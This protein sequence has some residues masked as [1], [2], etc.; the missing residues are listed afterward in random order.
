M[1][2]TEYELPANTQK[3]PEINT[4]KTR[5]HELLNNLRYYLSL[6]PHD[7]K[8]FENS[9]Q[10][11]IENFE[12]LAHALKSD[13]EDPESPLTFDR[14]INIIIAL[15]NKDG[16]DD[17]E[18]AKLAQK[19][20]DDFIQEYL[21]KIRSNQFLLDDSTIFTERLCF[22]LALS[23]CGSAGNEED[24]KASFY[25][26]K[27]IILKWGLNHVDLIN[28]WGDSFPKAKTLPIQEDGVQYIYKN[29]S[30]A[31]ILE[32]KRPGIVKVLVTEFGVKAFARYPLDSLIKQY[33]ERDKDDKPYGIILYARKDWNGAFTL[34][35][36]LFQK[37]SSDLDRCGYYLRIIEADSKI[38][39]A[40][41]LITFRKRYPN[42]K[43][44]FAL[45]GGHGTRSSIN[46]GGNDELHSL[47]L[48]DLS[49]EGLNKKI[50]LFFEFEPSIILNSCSTG[51]RIG[52]ARKLSESLG[53][54]V[55]APDCPA[56]ITDIVVSSAFF[57]EVYLKLYGENRI[58]FS[59][60]YRQEHSDDGP[61]K[62]Y[63][64]GF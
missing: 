60:F 14:T 52:I 8:I 28:S 47:Y 37:L 3:N 7:K 44:S 13:D 1:F 30:D 49:D 62:R 35:K 45:I 4:H 17:E 51:G 29:W 59:V 21:V 11:I 18:I 27:N 26:I 34:Q 43:I 25:L 5:K 41:A 2:I 53:A 46:F 61:G 10:S 31:I 32:S 36:D 54:K 57:H 33:D 6:P 20:Y 42:H 23:L 55:T 22:V 9:R 24:R 39:V 40:K 58:E 12:I 16:Y 15:K 64:F 63:H 19:T 50:R 48:K 56:T 38:D